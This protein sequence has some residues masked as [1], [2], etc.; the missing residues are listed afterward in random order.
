M[1]MIE[2]FAVLFVGFG[3]IVGVTFVAFTR[4]IAAGERVGNARK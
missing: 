4:G 1:E 3:A 2:A